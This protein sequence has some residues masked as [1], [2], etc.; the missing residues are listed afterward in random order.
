MSWVKLD[1]RFTSHR[2]VA[3]L[4]DRAFRLYVSSLCWSSENLTEGHIGTKDSRSLPVVSAARRPPRPSSR[5]QDCGTAP[6]MAGP[7]TTI[8][9]TTRR[10]PA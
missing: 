7:F 2:K 1:D 10:L 8:S 6:T 4:S 3:L 5:R 9:T